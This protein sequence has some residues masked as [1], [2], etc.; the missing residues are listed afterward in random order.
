MKDGED[1]RGEREEVGW[2][3]G[4]EGKEG[5]SLLHFEQ[6]GFRR[7]I[8]FDSIR[9][10]FSKKNCEYWI[11]EWIGLVGCRDKTGIGM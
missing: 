3:V 2:G 10:R 6:R 1:R 9:F 5:N 4:R 11:K 7:S 8:P